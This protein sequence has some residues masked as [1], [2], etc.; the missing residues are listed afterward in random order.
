MSKT[1]NAVGSIQGNS[2]NCFELLGFDF[3]FEGS[4][5][6]TAVPILIEVNMNPSMKLASSVS[7]SLLPFLIDDMLTLTVDKYFKPPQEYVEQYK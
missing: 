4:D 3:M 7:W 2:V 1:L 5:F 6:N